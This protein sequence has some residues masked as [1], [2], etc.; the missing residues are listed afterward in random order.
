MMRY[1]LGDQQITV[2]ARHIVNATGIFSEQV[3]LLTGQE[4]MAEVVP[5]K[6]VHLVF[7]REDVK[8]GSDAIVLPETDDKRILFI[9]PWQSRAIFGTTDTGSGDL[10]HPTA[11]PEDVSYLLA[12]LN[13]Y[14]SVH[15][16]EA[17]IIST[18]AG[19]RPLVSSRSSQHSTAKLSRTNPV[20]QSPSGLVTIVGG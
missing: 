11:T 17:D 7:S 14:L 3:E 18:Y 19:Y 8:L 6:G 15:L 9:V 5:S 2:R 4:P 10:D 20:L 13:R 12:H 16:T 1:R